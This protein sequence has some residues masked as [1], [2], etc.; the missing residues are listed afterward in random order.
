M[1]RTY[2]AVYNGVDYS[3]VFDPYYYADQYADLKQA[4]GYDCSQLLQHFINYGMSEGR[5]AK[6]SFN[7]TSYRLQY[8]D[9]RRAYGNDLKPYYMHYLQWGRSEGRQGTGCNVLQNG[10]TRYDGIDYAAVYDYNTYVSRY[11]DV[12][13]AYGYDDQAGTL[14]FIHYWNE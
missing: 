5:Q 14:H 1:E 11:S 2:N 13:R 8:S 3:S 12:F 7:A 9:L 4:Y 10:L 6:A